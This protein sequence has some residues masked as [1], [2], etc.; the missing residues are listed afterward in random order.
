MRTTQKFY[1]LIYNF[2]PR[3]REPGQQEYNYNLR[4]KRQQF[5]AQWLHSQE[6]F[7]FYFKKNKNVTPGPRA[8]NLEGGT[9]CPYFSWLLACGSFALP[10]MPTLIAAHWLRALPPSAKAQ[11]LQATFPLYC[12]YPFLIAPVID[13]KPLSSQTDFPSTPQ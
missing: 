7:Q 2:F 10:L 11:C 1:W 9:T 4:Q 5:L 3:Q 12:S 6:L 13:S 8:P